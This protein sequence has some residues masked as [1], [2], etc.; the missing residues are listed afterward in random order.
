MLKRGVSPLIATVLLIGFTIAVVATVTL[1][2]RTYVTELKQKQGAI[3]SSKLDCLTDIA[4]TIKGVSLSGSSL[5]V[6]VENLKNDVD[7]FVFVVR[8][9]KGQNSLEVLEPL[10]ASEVKTF[11]VEFNVFEVGTPEVVDVIPKVFIGPG[12]Y[13]PCSSKKVSYEVE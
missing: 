6:D 11:T 9:S 2:N 8:G 4:V 3:S 13:E 1:W 7:G 5:D 12:I 10:S